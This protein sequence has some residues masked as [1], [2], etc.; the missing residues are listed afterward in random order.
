MNNKFKKLIAVIT[1]T[2]VVLMM[3]AGCDLSCYDPEIID[4]LIAIGKL[5]PIDDTPETTEESEPTE[6]T[7]PE[8]PEPQKIDLNGTEGTITITEAGSYVVTGSTD[9]GMILVDATKKDVIDITLDNATI[10]NP[11]T[12]AICVMKAQ[13][14]N[15][16]LKGKC[17]LETSGIFET[18]EDNRVNAVIYSKTDLCIGGDG[19]VII[20][21]S[22]GKA[23]TCKD[24]LYI[25][26]GTYVIDSL[27]DAINGKDY[28]NISGGTITI[29]ASDDGIHADGKLQI[30]G[31]TITI[32]APEGLE[33]TYVV[34]NGGDISITSSDDGINA[35]LKDESYEK[36]VVE[37]NSGNITI[38]MGPGDTDGID[39]NGDIIINGGYIDITGSSTCDYD[40]TAT[41][42][43]GTLVLNGE[44][45]S[46]IPNQFFGPPPVDEN[47][48]PLPPPPM[49][50]ENGNPIDPPPMEFDENGNPLPPPPMYDENGNLLPPPPP[51]PPPP[52]LDGQ[53][54]FPPPSSQQVPTES[55]TENDETVSTNG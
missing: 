40:G 3:T 12:A 24:S 13:K 55:D 42:N 23:I 4:Y 32:D 52:G 8:V 45:A 14:V 54:G 7:E 17:K 51:P 10:I 20:S 38:V 35:S 48:N 18:T 37:I 47:G 1:A 6:V 25:T 36:P 39:S 44:E 43:G 26:D 16:T 5:V 31:G 46:E 22:Q 11:S 53:N 28:V 15:L 2:A 19:A 50:D 41:F 49:F 29:N 27:E 21:A 33:G 34:I 30:D 9:N